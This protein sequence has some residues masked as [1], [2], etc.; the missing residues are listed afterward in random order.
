MLHTISEVARAFGTRV[1][2]LRYYD[3][4]GLLHPAG[5]R[6]TVRTYGRDQLRRLAL[7][8]LLHRDGLMSLS[9]TAAILAE[10]PPDDQVAGRQILTD[11]IQSI[12]N[13]TER[14]RQAQHV[15]EHILT[16]PREDPIRDC[17]VLHEQL[18]QSVDA[19]LG[20][21]TPD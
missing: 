15:L 7:I 3:E 11:S 1:S 10:P 21:N 18:E 17:P 14:L 19:A 12:Q 5:R 13:Q 9:D 2:A 6:G 8:L 16:C 20:P 4:L